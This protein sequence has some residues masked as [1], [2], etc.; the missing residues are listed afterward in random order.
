MIEINNRK[1]FNDL[2]ATSAESA[3]RG[4]LA[5]PNTSVSIV[6]GGWT[7]GVD[8]E[9]FARTI[10]ESGARAFGVE[11]EV[12]EALRSHGASVSVFSSASEAVEAAYE[13]TP[14]GGVILISPGGAFFS[15]R[16]LLRGIDPII[17]SL[18]SR[19]LQA[20]RPK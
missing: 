11:S 12:S 15:S 20:D 18:R 1:I 19:I 3:R 16:F 5:F 17:S 7:K 10:K 6:V 2:S 4:L 13:N 8:Y 9:S 14:K